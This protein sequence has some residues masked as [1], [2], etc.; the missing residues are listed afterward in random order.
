LLDDDGPFPYDDW[1]KAFRDRAPAQTYRTLSAA[2][3]TE[4]V[5]SGLIELGSHTHSHQDFRGRPAEFLRD[6]E[7]SLE[8]MSSR[9]GQR[10]VP[11]AFPWGRTYSE[12]TGETLLEAVRQTDLT[13]ALTTQ[14]QSVEPG[15]DPF[16]WGRYNVFSWDTGATLAAKLDGWYSWAPK[17]RQRLSRNVKQGVSE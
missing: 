5:E 13:C 1:G 2:D 15:S 9:L 14:C 6:V 12:T 3:C 4:M 7:T 11:F 10:N 8:I 16:G 17:L